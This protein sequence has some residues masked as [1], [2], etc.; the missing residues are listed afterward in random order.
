MV[1]QRRPLIVAGGGTFLDDLL[2]KARVENLAGSS[3]L[4]YPHYSMESVISHH[5]D[6]ILD[7]DISPQDDFWQRYPSLID[8][9]ER[10]DP[11]FFIP[12]PRL[13]EALSV[14]IEKIHHP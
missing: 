11:D 2:K 6:V 4:P 12:G 14:L 3:K 7:L 1:V 5:P 9:V 8:S 10:L 13:P